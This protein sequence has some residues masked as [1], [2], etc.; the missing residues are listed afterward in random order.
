MVSN[1]ILASAVIFLICFRAPASLF[2]IFPEVLSLGVLLAGFWS[3][4]SSPLQP[5]IGCFVLRMA[6]FALIWYSQDIVSIVVFALG[7]GLTF[8]VTAPLTVVL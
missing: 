4:Q 7:Y 1:A 5:T 6:L 8:L 3:D 2:L